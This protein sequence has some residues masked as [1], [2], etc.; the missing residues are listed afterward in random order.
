MKNVNILVFPCGSE[1]GLEIHRALS[2]SKFITLFGGSSVQSNHGKYV[3]ERYIENLSHVDEPDFIEK[4]NSVIKKYDIDYVFPA[5]DS[6]VLK[7]AENQNDLHC[8]VIG[9]SFE[10]CELTR[11]KKKTYE[12]FEDKIETPTVYSHSSEV[13]NFPVFL[14]PDIGQGAKGTVLANSTEEI[15]FYLKKDPTLLILENLPGE[16]YTIDCFTDKSGKLKFVGVRER[17]RI[18]NGISVNSKMIKEDNEF[19][20]IAE[21]INSSI[22]F[23]GVWFFQLKRSKDNKLSLLEISAR[24]AGAMGYFRNMGV[25][26]P[27]LSI[28]DLMGY[29]VEINLNNYSMEMDRSL[30][31]RFSLDIEYDNVYID[32]DDTLVCNGKVNVILVSFI[33]ECI[34]NNKKIFLLTRHQYNIQDSLSKYKLSTLFDDIYHLKNREPKSNYIN[35]QNSIFIDDSYAE[36]IEVS[37]KLNIPTFDLDSVESL[38]SIKR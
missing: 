21:A 6:V 32:F 10:T 12:F 4:L 23:R 18:S 29:D 19:R 1:I 34:N 22:T 2:F 36:R 24:V 14:K 38:I 27:L 5:H 33:Y 25:N 28:F 9:S 17:T 26:L 16:E 31:S 15:E 8:K 7:L 35:S 30:V 3:Y 20:K 11:S 37:S 13:N